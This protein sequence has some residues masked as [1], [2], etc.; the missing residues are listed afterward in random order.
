MFTIDIYDLRYDNGKVMVGFRYHDKEKAEEVKERYS[1]KYKGNSQ[2][3][4]V[5]NF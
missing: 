1:N 4:V 5:S 3:R 2:V